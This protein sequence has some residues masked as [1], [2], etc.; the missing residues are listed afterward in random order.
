MYALDPRYRRIPG[1][2]SPTELAELIQNPFRFLEARYHAH[3]PIFRSSLVYPVVWMIGPEAN[4][5]IMVQRREI[6]SYEGGYGQLAFGRLFPRNILVMD[7]AEHLHVR[8]ILEPAVSRLGLE[9]SLDRVQGIWDD[10]A[11]RL[12]TDVPLDAYTTAQR[13]TF[14]VSAR[15]LTGLE[16]TSELDAMRPL[17]E[18]VI[19]GS[20]AATKIRWP[21]GVLDKGLDA[22]DALVEKLR[23][24][25]ERARRT[26]ST[27]FLGRLAQHREGGEY[28]P[29]EEVIHHVMLLFWAGYDTTASAGSWILHLLAHHPEWQ[30]RIRSEVFEVLGDAPYQLAGSGRL[31][32]VSMFLREV[33]RYAPSLIMFPRKATEGFEF[34]GHYV[35]KGTPVYY[36]PWMTHRCPQAF[37]HPHSF[38]PGRWD[39]ERG[40]DQAKGKYMVG[41]GGGPRLCLGRQFAQM[42]LRVLI[43]TL[44]RRFHIEPDPTSTFHIM[45]LP[46]HHPVD[47][48]LHFRELL[49]WQK[50]REELADA[51]E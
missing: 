27:G 45:G 28:L 16:D 35:P 31:Q 49:G 3:G 21:R 46:V 42:Q 4:R 22:R 29:V 32:T 6:F 33:E 38:D 26:E 40:D 47:S 43:T 13:T 15:A 1:T 19:D 48:R 36:S 25:V 24:H 5:F 17:F 23:P 50:R 11:D 41:F 34:G 8:G 12:R 44:V 37:P 10:A 30:A 9:E 14:E 20:M 39:P 18:A 2:S 51:A 7:G